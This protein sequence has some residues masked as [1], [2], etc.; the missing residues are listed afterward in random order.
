MHAQTTWAEL[1]AVETPTTPCRSRLRAESG[2]LRSQ[3]PR[4][5]SGRERRRTR[6]AGSCAADRTASR[7][8]DRTCPSSLQPGRRIARWPL[9]REQRAVQQPSPRTRETFLRPTRR[10]PTR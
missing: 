9:R 6:G 10:G 4:L 3:S 1:S 7:S 8:L 2:P 5:R